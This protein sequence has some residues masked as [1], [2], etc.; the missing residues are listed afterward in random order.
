MIAD[1]ILICLGVTVMLTL[2]LTFR[3]LYPAY[4]SMKIHESLTC[5]SRCIYK[6]N[7]DALL[8]GKIKQD[9]HL[10]D[11]FYP[12]MVNV[13]TK[14]VNLKLSVLRD[15]KYNKENEQEISRFQDEVRSLDSKTH[16]IIYDSIYALSKIIFFRNP[17]IFTL[18]MR[19]VRWSKRKVR[20]S[21]RNNKFTTIRDA[22]KE[23]FRERSNRS[24]AFIAL[25]DDNIGGLAYQ[26][27]KSQC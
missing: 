13:F 27:I 25:N 20:W 26:P 1:T 19:K 12:F 23:I 5:L 7:R 10:H 11:D 9:S 3:Y 17:V 24:T 21:K 2:W 18:A 6:L 16:D 15:I 14:K 4:K 8:N 22:L